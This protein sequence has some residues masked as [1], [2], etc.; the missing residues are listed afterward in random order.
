MSFE[1]RLDEALGLNEES[2]ILGGLP[3]VQQVLYQGPNPDG[4]RKKCENCF[5]W[6]KDNKCLAFAKDQPVK[7]TQVCGYHVF[8]TPRPKWEDMGVQHMDT[9]LAGLEEVGSGTSCDICEYYDEGRCL[10][11]KGEDGRP[12]KVE[13][14]GCCARWERKS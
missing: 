12:A 8:G 11:V 6:C 9:K 4:S 1:K 13:P 14:K 2:R 5:M 10:A 3:H 7:K